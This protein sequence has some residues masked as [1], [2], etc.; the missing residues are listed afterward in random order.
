VWLV[1]R[2]LGFW[3]ISRW[4]KMNYS[5]LSQAAPSLGREWMGGVQIILAEVFGAFDPT[6]WDKFVWIVEILGATVYDPLVCCHLGLSST[7]KN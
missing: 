7:A 2:V 3:K 4:G 5:L 1:G 6:L